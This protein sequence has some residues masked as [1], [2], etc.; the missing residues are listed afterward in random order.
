MKPRL[1]LYIPVALIFFAACN[2]SK[3]IGQGQ[4]LYN[5]NSIEI[6]S[7]EN[8]SSKQKKDLRNDLDALLR[9]KLNGSILGIRFKLWIYNIA[10]NPKK[11]KGLRHWLKYKVGEPPVLA[12]QPALEKNRSVLQNHLENKGFF[13]D[14]VTLDTNVNNKKLNAV[15]TAHIGTQYTIRN[16]TYPSGADTLSKEIASLQRRSR[17][18][19]GKPYDLD[20]IKDE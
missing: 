7:S 3:H 16:V 15:Y 14:S 20:V 10:G 2:E 12:T 17:L 18:V 9:P 5:S 11:E 6:K 8:I 1:I 19:K 4:Y 13:H